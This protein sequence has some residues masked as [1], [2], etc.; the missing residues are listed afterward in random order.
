MARAGSR[1]QSEAVDPPPGRM[2]PHNG[3]TSAATITGQGTDESAA[4]HCKPVALFVHTG[5][6]RAR[7]R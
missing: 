6:C 4:N 5:D 1:P 3:V 2:N 7:I